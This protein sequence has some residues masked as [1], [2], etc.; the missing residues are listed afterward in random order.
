MAFIIISMLLS[1]SSCKNENNPLMNPGDNCISC[2]DG[3]EASKFTA[4]GTVYADPEAA[5]DSGLAGVEIHITDSEGHSVTLKSN[6][7]GNFYTAEKLTPPLNKEVR[8]NGI[9]ISS[10]TQ[11]DTGA[12]ATCHTIPPAQQ[13]SGRIYWREE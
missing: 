4:A 3:S 8:K 2:H 6:D 1:I 9:T 10:S 7:A 5:A 12:C 11:A 13:T